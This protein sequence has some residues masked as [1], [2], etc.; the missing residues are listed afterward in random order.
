MEWF[1]NTRV[2]ILIYL[3]DALQAQQE[4][5]KSIISLEWAGVLRHYYSAVILGEPKEGGREGA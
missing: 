2:N 1:L 5:M 4:G 3:F